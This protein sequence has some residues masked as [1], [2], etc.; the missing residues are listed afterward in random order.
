MGHSPEVEGS[1]E[2]LFLVFSW[3][4]PYDLEALG[5]ADGSC[6]CQMLVCPLGMFPRLCLVTHKINY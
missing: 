5:E 6:F 2:M 1:W 4:R 3:I